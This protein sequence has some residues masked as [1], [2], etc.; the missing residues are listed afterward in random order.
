MKIGNKIFF[1]LCALTIVAGLIIY[2][3]ASAFQKKAKITEGTVIN[4]GLSAYEIQYTSD[5]GAK[6]VYRGNHGSS[7]GWRYHTGDLVKVFYRA[8]NP[9]NMRF[10]DGVKL[11]RKVMIIGIIMTLFNL[12]SLWFGWK[13]NKSEKNF[14]TTGRKLQARILQ[15]GIDTGISVLKKN[16]FYIDCEWEDQVSGRK[17][18]HTI[19]YIWTDPKIL[20]NERETIDVYI[21][22]DNPAKY[23]MDIS[24]LG[25]AAK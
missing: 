8:D 1:V 12:I 7:K 25:E 23:F 4:T 22:P 18:T 13:K 9:E 2:L 11:G 20:L 6:R 21:D 15:I 24:F 17:Y 19:R 16:P 14:K 3:E 5:D 10:S